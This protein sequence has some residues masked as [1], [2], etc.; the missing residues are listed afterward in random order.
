MKKELATAAW[1]VTY[2]FILNQTPQLQNLKINEMVDLFATWF[3]LSDPHIRAGS[4]GPDNTFGFR[5]T[6]SG[7]GIFFF[8][9][10]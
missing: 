1:D 2:R 10:S 9:E 4:I 3:L 8:K 6:F 5:E 7:V